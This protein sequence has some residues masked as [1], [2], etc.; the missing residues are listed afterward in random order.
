MATLDEEKQGLRVRARKMRLVADQKHGPVAAAAAASKLLSRLG[1]VGARPGAVFA[2]YWPI[3]TEID[4]R[5][6]LARLH[7]R[8]YVCALPVVVGR[9]A[10]L[11]FRRWAPLDELD[12]GEHETWQPLASAPEVVPD[13]VIVP[14]LAFDAQG[15]RLGQGVGYYDRTLAALRSAGTV[16]TVGMAYAAQRFQA[17]P[18]GP[19][20][21][22][23]DWLL[24]EQSLTRA[25]P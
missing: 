11:A 17:V 13:V 18:H 12:P 25:R 6:L 14:L 1:D 7:E 16:V 8:G 24:T 9:S 23:M 3:A 15:W 20:D 21:Q 2:G 19:L 5:P 10:P 4:D 22:P